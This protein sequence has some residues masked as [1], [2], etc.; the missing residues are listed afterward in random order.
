M[1][2][3]YFFPDGSNN[4]KRLL[5][6]Q[7]NIE[8]TELIE[9]CTKDF[10][11]ANFNAAI[12]SKGNYQ[13]FG[14]NNDL[15]HILS[16]ILEKEATALELLVLG[17]QREY[18]IY[19]FSNGIINADNEYK[20]VNDF[21][22]VSQGD[23]TFYL[24]AFSF[25]NEQNIGMKN[26]RDFIYREGE[27]DVKRWSKLFYTMY[28]ER[29]A[30]GIAYTIATIF[31]DIIFKDFAHFPF[32][33]LFGSASTG[34]TTFVDCLSGIFY[35]EHTGISLSNNSTSKA[36]ARRLAQ[37]RN[38]PLYLKEFKNSKADNTSNYLLSAYDGAGYDRAQMSNDNRTHQTGV[39]CALIIDGNEIPEENTPVFSRV[40]LLK[41]DKNQITAE[42]THAKECFET[43]TAEGT[44]QILKS[45]IAHRDHINTNYSY[46]YKRI[47][48]HLKQSYFSDKECLERN[49][50]HA[51]LIVTCMTLLIDK[52]EFPFTIAELEEWVCKASNF[53]NDML[54]D[55]DEVTEFWNT[56]N[57]LA[58]NAQIKNN[59]EYIVKSPLKSRDHVLCLRFNDV[60]KSYEKSQRTTGHSPISKQT[61][62]Q[63]LKEQKYFIACT[64]EGDNNW[65]EPI[66]GKRYT[67]FDYG[68]MQSI[69]D[70]SLSH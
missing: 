23:K 50:E 67:L 19:A 41:F 3:V 28:G 20:P 6:I 12:R 36:M 22:I 31:R 33:Y 53:Q 11:V 58:I 60:Y 46:E 38:A 32:L 17:Y 68:M 15:G 57:H 49:I 52:F 26:E 7:R 48:K 56:I 61:L 69:Y 59:T 34:K 4:A 63:M 5:K 10:T 1:E 35:K 66:D 39:D 47:K 64:G 51:A 16:Y 70:L 29:A 27:I 14:S 62:I 54:R 45:I 24:P 37:F 18:N 44:G 21:G 43:E 42:T 55:T 25:L 2:I 13:F 40:I 9:L 8:K 30:I 65:T